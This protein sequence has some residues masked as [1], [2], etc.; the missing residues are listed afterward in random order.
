[1]DYLKKYWL[2]S[3][4]V[5]C[6]VAWGVVNLMVEPHD[7]KSVKSTNEILQLE[8]GTEKLPPQPS[9]IVEV[10]HKADY[11]RKSLMKGTAFDSSFGFNVYISDLNN[12]LKKAALYITFENQKDKNYRNVEVGRTIRIK[13]EEINYLIEIEDIKEEK[14]DI[15]I[16]KEA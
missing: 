10:D 3:V 9:G 4:I 7:S 16:H 14:I 6:G 1:M 11:E 13:Q 15:L 12:D 8:A 2:L 5:L